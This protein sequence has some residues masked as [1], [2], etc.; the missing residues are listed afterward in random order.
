MILKR[1]FYEN[2][3]SWFNSDKVLLVD[4][5]RQVGKTFLIREFC[6]DNFTNFIEINLATEPD[7]IAM[8]E[9]AKSVSDFLFAI[10]A[11]ADA[12]LIEKNT[13]I[14][15]DEI[16]KAKD[17]DLIGLAKPLALDGRYRYI[18]SGSLLGVTEF[19]I[20]LEPTGFLYS[21]RMYPLDFEEFLWANSI[22]QEVIDK[23]K[24]CFDNKTEVPSFIHDKFIDL[25]YKYLLI[26][27][28]PEA[29]S[30]YLEKNDLKALNIVFKAIEQHYLRDITKYAPVEERAYIRQAYS[31]LPSELNSKSKRF[32]L[33][34]ID[35]VNKLKRIDNS[36][37]WLSDAG[38]AIPVYN[39][40]EPKAPLYLAMNNRL[41]KLFSSDMGML[42]YRLMDTD[43]QKKILSHEKN[44]N[45]GAI[46]E[47][48]VAQELYC[49]G[50]DELYYFSSK[51]QGE[52]DFILTY[53][54]DVLPLEIKSGKDYSRHVALNN[55]LSNKEYEINQAY[56]FYDGNI[57]RKDKITYF[58]IYMIEFLR[59]YS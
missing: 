3:K 24:E 32:T 12:P 53:K 50:F 22:Q 30:C 13:V 34:R 9:K 8:L 27:G 25:F 59:R 56:V 54:G 35:K 11:I 17:I 4:G 10:T 48:A 37:L 6:K 40:D 16:Q 51:K 18:F 49:H 20:G 45:Y 7:A 38:I 46:F 19:N 52:V 43:T 23:V 55:L 26:G 42:S 44:M 39:V 21:E 15:I 33:S 47:N 28:M 57:K 29:V 1:K 5:A 14:F 31:I 58:P 36:F 41:L 2:L